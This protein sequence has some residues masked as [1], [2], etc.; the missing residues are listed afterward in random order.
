MPDYADV[1]DGLRGGGPLAHWR[2]GDADGSRR[3][4]ERIGGRHAAIDGAVRFGAARLPENSDAA[5]DFGGTG[6]ATVAHD[7]GLE[8]AAFTLSFWLK[9]NALP[10]GDVIWYIINKG[11]AGGFDGDLLVRLDDEGG[12]E[13]QLQ[14]ATPGRHSVSADGLDTD[15]AYH[16]CMRADGE[17]FDAY[18]NGQYLGKNT[19]FLGA[20]TAN[21]QDLQF[22]VAPFSVEPANVVL[23]EILLYDRKLSEREVLTLAQRTQAP[24]AVDD[25]VKVPERGTTPIE[26]LANDTYVGTPELSVEEQPEGGDLAAPDGLVI[27][28]TAGAVAENTARS[29]RYRITDQNGE[30]NIAT[31]RVS[32]RAKAARLVSNANCYVESG[33]GTVV[34]N[35]MNDLVARVNDAHSTGL[36]QI[37]I[38]A[39]EYDGRNLTFEPRGTEANPIVIRPRG[40]IGTVTINEAQWTLA[41]TS[42]WLVVSKLFFNKSRI[43]LNGDHNRITR[44][45]WRQ[46]RSAAV[47]FL[48]ARD[49]RVDH[50]DFSESMSKNRQGKGS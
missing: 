46:L 6:S 38:A 49:C 39:N 15:R 11:Q 10:A 32:V 50:C 21:H 5:I 4:T 34:V 36:R 28:Y 35:N 13:I 47:N 40:D 19:G 43:V 41:N 30:S 9:L 18:L 31:V 7:A 24:K 17:G 44:C 48:T 16:V 8:L 45:R 27:K 14:S 23:D 20:I 33:T 1:A 12:L 25:A 22:A 3:L 26:V 37:L 29:F 42:S 2:L